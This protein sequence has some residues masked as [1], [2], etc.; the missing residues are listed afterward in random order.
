MFII[1][2]AC[3]TVLPATIKHEFLAVNNGDNRLHYVNEFEPAKNWMV[4]IPAESRNIQLL[5]NDSVLVGHGNG[6]AIYDKKTGA[7]LR[8][9]T[10]SLTGIQCAM[11]RDNG[12]YLLCQAT[13]QF[14][15]L[16]Q[17]GAQTS[18]FTVA[19]VSQVRLFRILANGNFLFTTTETG[20]IRETT[21]AGVKVWEA[22]LPGK[23]YLALRL[24][25]GN[26]M[27][28]AF[29]A[30]VIVEVNTAGT[31]V[32]KA[33]VCDGKNGNAGICSLSGFDT[34]AG[35]N[36]VV[37]NWQGDGFSQK[38]TEPHIIEFTRNNEIVWTW[39]DPTQQ[40]ITNV[41]VLD[42]SKTGGQVSSRGDPIR[43]RFAGEKPA[44]CRSIVLKH[45]GIRNASTDVI[46]LA[47]KRTP[48][49]R[50]NSAHA[51]ISIDRLH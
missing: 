17:S 30:K 38:H 39:K 49:A 9:I 33:G 23:G 34:L 21:S 48:T 29:T 2:T 27:A 47:G 28:T 22:A 19:D 35:G 50:N 8:T 44:H 31:I 25:S 6:C 26:T 45:G 42:A 16:D 18:S 41:M 13:G 46:N 37:C 1:V 51:A 5:A 43:G 36:V 40:Y 15:D 32:W 20:R 14:Y 7:K 12:R 11:R 4:S 10:A 3:G 24:P